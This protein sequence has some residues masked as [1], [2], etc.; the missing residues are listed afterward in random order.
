[1]IKWKK[2]DSYIQSESFEK[3]KSFVSQNSI[4]Q[5]ELEN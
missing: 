5:T 4:E 3:F 2:I 1:M